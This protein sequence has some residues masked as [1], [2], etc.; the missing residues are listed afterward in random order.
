[1]ALPFTDNGSVAGENIGVRK[2][3]YTIM[4]EKQRREPGAIDKQVGGIT[5]PGVGLDGADGPGTVG[6]QSS[7]VTIVKPDS[8]LRATVPRKVVKRWF[9]MWY[10]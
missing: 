10:P 6:D 3:L 2:E 5:F 4:L 1:M 9:S 8:S 7:Y